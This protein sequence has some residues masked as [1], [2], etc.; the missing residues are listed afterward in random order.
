MPDP[1]QLSLETF[2]DRLDEEFRLHA[3]DE[4]VLDIVLAEAVRLGD[5]AMPGG[6]VPFSIV[7]R[8]S[9][10]PGILPQRIYRLEHDALGS[11]ELFLVPL[12]PDAQ[13]TRYE[14]VV[15]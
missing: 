4:L 3:S 13:G 8:G 6:R 15:N 9:I 1:P 2:T 11:F 5:P 7:F 14:A 10:G 12:E